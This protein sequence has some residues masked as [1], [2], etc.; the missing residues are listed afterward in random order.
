MVPS[1]DAEPDL[2]PGVGIAAATGNSVAIGFVTDDKRSFAPERSEQRTNVTVEREFLQRQ[3]RAR[4]GIGEN[5]AAVLD[6][7]SGDGQIIRTPSARGNRPVDS[8]GTV[9]REIDLRRH[10]ARL[11][12]LHLAA[13]ERTKPHLEIERTGAQLWL[14]ARFTDLDVAQLDARG[15]QD[16][17]VDRTRDA[18]AQSGKAARLGLECRAV[19]VPID[20]E[21]RHQRRNERQND[22]DRQ[23]EQRRLHGVSELSLNPLICESCALLPKPK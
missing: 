9:E 1:I 13:D 21:R 18:H 16:A 5:D 23:S 3:A 8:A 10:Q 17:R 15:R 12:G 7:Q 19:M 14:P 4:R 11:G 22:R 20:D 2:E 6:A